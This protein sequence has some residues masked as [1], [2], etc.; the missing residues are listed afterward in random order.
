L[1]I[2]RRFAQQQVPFP[3]ELMLVIQVGVVGKPF[4]LVREDE[5]QFSMQI[6]IVGVVSRGLPR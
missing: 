2:K 5:R 3:R 4:Q 1:L 6:E